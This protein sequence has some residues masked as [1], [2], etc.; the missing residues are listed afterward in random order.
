[1]KRK[2]NKGFTLI[3]LLVVITILAVLSIIGIAAFRTLPDQANDS[4]RRSDVDSIAKVL[5]SR[6]D[7]DTGYPELSAG[8]FTSGQKPQK[9]EGGD[10]DLLYSP[11]ATD[12]KTFRVCATLSDSTQYCRSSSLGR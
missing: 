6:Y 2:L 4:R 3:E 7:V 1:M 12:R 9:P 8:D 5:E 10:Y 11:G